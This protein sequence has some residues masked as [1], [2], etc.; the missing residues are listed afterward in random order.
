MGEYMHIIKQLTDSTLRYITSLPY[1]R[2]PDLHGD[3]ARAWVMVKAADSRQKLEAICSAG[4]LLGYAANDSTST[5]RTPRS[6]LEYQLGRV[7]SA[8]EGLNHALSEKYDD[9]PTTQLMDLPVEVLLPILRFACP[10]HTPGDAALVNTYLEMRSTFFKLSYVCH[11]WANL[12]RAISYQHIVLLTDPWTLHQL[13]CV[14]PKFQGLV[15]AITLDGVDIEGSPHHILQCQSYLDRI[16][17]MCP[18]LDSLS[19]YGDYCPFKW[20]KSLGNMLQKQKMQNNVIPV[21]RAA[22]FSSSRMDLGNQLQCFAPD[23]ES[24]ALSEGSLHTNQQMSSTVSLPNL[25]SLSV[26][27]ATRLSKNGLQDLLSISAPGTI[28]HLALF[29]LY[30]ISEAD[31]LEMLRYNSFGLQLTSLHRSFVG[32]VLAI[33]F[34]QQLLRLCPSLLDFSFGHPVSPAISEV[35]PENLQ[36]LEV[37]VVSRPGSEDY[38]DR[39]TSGYEPLLTYIRSEKSQSLKRLSVVRRVILRS[40]NTE[41]VRLGLYRDIENTYDL[42]AECHRRGVVFSG[43]TVITYTI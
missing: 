11:L 34:P 29:D 27:R 18:N 37:L 17:A 14:L 39:R 24:L 20:N 4:T 3:A 13:E 9:K 30:S 12:I 31:L 8:I 26:N 23:M 42:R 25:K 36:S 38:I 5:D 43:R 2:S 33:D 41:M 40:T 15:K 1:A 35:L 10:T 32:V 19:I 6:L 7:D 16:I 28:Q 22:I 21:K